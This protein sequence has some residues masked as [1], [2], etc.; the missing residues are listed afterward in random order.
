MKIAPVTADTVRVFTSGNS[1]AIRLPKKFRLVGRTARI[2]RK[3]KSLVITPEEDV[4]ARF[5]RGIAGFAGLWEGF[6]REQPKKT[7]RCPDIFP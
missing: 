7:D 5:E 4:W 6:E 3:G 2:T 1:Q